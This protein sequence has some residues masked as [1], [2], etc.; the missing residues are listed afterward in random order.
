MKQQHLIPSLAALGNQLAP[1]SSPAPTRLEQVPATHRLHLPAGQGQLIWFDAGC[2]LRCLEGT[3]VFHRTLVTE[4]SVMRLPAHTA[5]RSPQGQWL[6]IEA[7]ARGAVLQ[8]TPAARP[9]PAR[10]HAPHTSGAHKKSRPGNTALL[11]LGDAL[12]KRFFRPAQ[13]AG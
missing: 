12:R 11:R 2:E 13:P 3:A 4:T 9:E 8:M 7:E 10:S 1:L 5:W 6:G